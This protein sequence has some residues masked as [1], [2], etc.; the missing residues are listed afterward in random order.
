MCIFKINMQIP[1]WT[2][3]RQPVNVISSANLLH[4]L[5]KGTDATTFLFLVRLSTKENFL[6]WQSIHP[7]KF[8]GVICRNKMHTNCRV[9]EA[10][11][12]VKLT[13]VLR[14]YIYCLPQTRS[15]HWES[16]VSMA[17]VHFTRCY[18]KQIKMCN[19]SERLSV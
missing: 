19:D 11:S 16:V 12:K 2:L 3:I 18:M 14:S 1:L 15:C 7:S 4:E 10:E 8:R 13:E 6:K 5:L 9:T 17:S